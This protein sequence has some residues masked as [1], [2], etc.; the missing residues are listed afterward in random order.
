[1]RHFRLKGVLI[2]GLASLAMQASAHAQEVTLAVPE[3]PPALEPCAMSVVPQARIM[4]GNVAEGLTEVDSESGEISPLLATEWTR[5]GPTEW[6]FKLRE[7][8]TFHDGTPFDADA[9][10]ASINRAWS[11]GIVCSVVTQVFGGVSVSATAVDPT[12]LNLTTNSPDLL[13]PRRMSFMGIIAKSA[14]MDRATDNPISTGPYKLERWDHGSS[15]T[16]VRN[17]DYWGEKPE[18]EKATYLFRGE[19]SVRADMV[20]LGEAD[21]ALTLP[22]EFGSRNGAVQ[23]VTRNAIV[24]RSDAL[25][26]PLSDKRVRDAIAKAVN[27]DLLVEAIWEGAA[28]PASQV[29][30]PDVAGHN[31]DIEPIEYDPEGAKALIDE[32]RAD[33]VPVDAELTIY[34][35]AG[36]FANSAQ[37]GEVLAAE[38]NGI[39]LNVRMTTLEVGPWTEILRTQ[40][41]DR[42]ALLLEDSA[43]HMG[44]PAGTFG[45]RY[46]STQGRSQTPLDLRPQFDELFNEAAQAEGDERARLFS[47]LATWVHDNLSV[48]AYIAYP[49][50]TMMI[51]PRI[52]YTPNVRSSHVI[53]LKEITVN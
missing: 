23:F 42:R 45:S 28:I 31:H 32:A 30:T 39:G 17:E 22:P 20:D 8:V 41:V 10:A 1:M 18:I 6:Q 2:A 36:L 16:V 44:D 51:G 26:A 47:E 43:D 40:G 49:M 19:D 15:V 35:R 50:Q 11:G 12:T 14:P 34:N 3:E 48:D 9:A 27:R 5:L 4:F 38:L 24:L 13:L 7:G 33:G 21:L 25:T 53:R 46:V 29:T 52:S 37:L